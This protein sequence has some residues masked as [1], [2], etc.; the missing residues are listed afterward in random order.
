MDG[1]LIDLGDSAVWRLIRRA[2]WR[3]YITYDELDRLLPAGHVSAEQ[4]KDVLSLLSEIGIRAVD[5][6]E[7]V[8]SAIPQPANSNE[9][10]S[11]TH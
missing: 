7:V 8:G 2:K 5:A 6:A 10:L 11:E 1:P 4:I 9:P 3:G